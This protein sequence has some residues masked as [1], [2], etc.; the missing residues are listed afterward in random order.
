MYSHM[1]FKIAMDWGLLGTS[2]SFPFG[3]GVP[4]AV[5]LSLSYSCVLG[6]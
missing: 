3:L 6:V 4:M 5:I 2:P 1:Y